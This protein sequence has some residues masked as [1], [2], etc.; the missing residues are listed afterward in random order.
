[1][2]RQLCHTQSNFS[3][4][5]P[6]L[7]LPIIL[8]L[9]LSPNFAFA[10]RVVLTSGRTLNGAV[11][12]EGPAEVHIKTDV[13]TLRVRRSDVKSVVREDTTPE[14]VDGDIAL[15]ARNY[16]AALKSYDAALARAG[17][18]EQAG[19]RLKKKITDIKAARQRTATATI[20]DQLQKAQQFIASKQ[21]DQ[22]LQIFE[23]IAPNLPNDEA[24]SSV[25]HMIAEAHFAK[26]QIARDGQNQLGFER[27]L[28]DAITNF[29]P[30]YRAHLLY[31]ENLMRSAATEQQG[32]DEIQAGLKYGE[33]EMGEDERMK[34]QYMLAQRFFERGK[35]ELAAANFAEC[36]RAKNSYPD[37]LDWAVK[38]YLKLGEQTQL[39]DVQKTI[40]NLN[41]AL[42]LNPQNKDAR[43]LLGKIYKETGQTDKAI[44]QFLKVITIDS[45]YREA[46]HLVAQAYREKGDYENAL[47]YFDQELKNDPS[48]YEALVDRADVEILQAAYDKASADLEQAK[49]IEPGKWRAY[50]LTAQLNYGRQE[51][52]SAIENLGKVM[53]IKPDAVEAHIQMGKVLQ[54]QKNYDS[55]KLWFNNVVTNLEKVKNLSFKYR[56]L[57]A[58]AQTSLGDIDLQQENPRQADTRLRQALEFVP[59][60]ADAFQKIGDVKRA[61]GTE[62]AAEEAKNDYFKQA[63]Q[64]YQRAIESNPRNPDYY[65][66][67][68]ILYH[69]NLKDTERAVVNYN[70]YLISNGRDRA[71]VVKWIEECGG[72][73]VED[74]N[75]TET[76][77]STASE[78]IS[79]TTSNADKKTSGT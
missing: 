71:N 75:T 51:Y 30:Y 28:K 66:S 56:T 4:V 63:E 42:R 47:K 14:E 70:K 13:G 7:A 16:E 25:R 5:I 60:F 27:E 2:K 76:A 10:D 37:A 15:G 46:N 67:L 39:S 24:T 48:N 41:E 61:L 3:P 45:A 79:G 54:A 44:E 20:A 53:S 64:Y 19:P 35:Y 68:G 50:L 29:P 9:L 78:T 18:S 32:I 26:A 31:G 49:K 59:N 34:Y 12:F 40:N 57:M 38:S 73:A 8:S 69:K 1:M 22:A 77:T 33:S 21:Y 72:T 65:L 6:A 55:A 62:T 11:I 17:T 58:E 74:I 36:L 23:Q 43:F 52:A